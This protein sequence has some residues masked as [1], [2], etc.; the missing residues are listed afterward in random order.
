MKLEEILML[1]KNKMSAGDVYVYCA[2]KV[3]VV[4]NKMPSINNELIP[5]VQMSRSSVNRSIVKLEQNNIITCIKE[6]GF[7]KTKIYFN[8]INQKTVKKKE[9]KK[10]KCGIYKIYIDSDVYVGQSRNIEQRWKDHEMQINRDI[11]PYFT[12]TQAEH[13]SYEILEE[14]RL[15]ELRIKEI[16][17]AQRIKD[18]GLKVLNEENFTLI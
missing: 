18:K 8:K 11:H 13:I 7:N 17:W 12:S 5:A 6:N 16:L 2:L 15:S 1:S 3:L 10:P 9:I 14:C 4:D